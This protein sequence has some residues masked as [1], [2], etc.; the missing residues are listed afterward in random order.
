MDTSSRARTLSQTLFSP[1][2]SAAERE[3][4]SSLWLK[5][6]SNCFNKVL[7]VGEPSL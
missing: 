2:A 4:A 1:T 6:A 3:E 5:S 7:Y